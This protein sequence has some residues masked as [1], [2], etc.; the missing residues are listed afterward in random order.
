MAI[1]CG[2]VV[3]V[4]CSA[5]SS[6]PNQATQNS[7]SGSGPGADAGSPD[8]LPALLARLAAAEQTQS[9]NAASCP[10]Y[11]YVRSWESVF[12][13]V[14]LTVVQVVDGKPSWRRHWSRPKS[15]EWASAVPDWTEG[16][17][18]IGTNPT[19]EGLDGRVWRG[20][21]VPQ[22]FAECRA[23]FSVEP[24]GATVALKINEQGIPVA[25]LRSSIGCVD[26]C[27]NG[28]FIDTFECGTQ[29]PCLGPGCPG[30][31]PYD[32]TCWRA[33]GCDAAAVCAPLA[34]GTACGAG[35]CTQGIC[36]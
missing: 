12:G 8:P 7:D 29:D 17:S 30:S 5:D 4:G 11:H 10:S 9:A 34:D 15:N 19:F 3:A 25:C 2:C 13:S 32:Y 21:D 36:R 6:L 33:G 1:L 28:F 27:S 14:G 22:L 20:I 18:E 16:A 26:D 35:V 24:S 23:I 31:G